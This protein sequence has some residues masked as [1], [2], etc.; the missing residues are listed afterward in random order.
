MEETFQEVSTQE[1]YALWARVY[2]EEKNALIAVEEPYVERL[3]SL[4]VFENALDVGTG[5]GRLALKLAHHGGRV[6]ALDQSPEMLSV[7]R[8]SAAREGLEID[9]RL[10]SLENGVFTEQQFDLLTSGLMLCHVP[11]LMHAAQQ[12][13]GALQTGGSALITDFHPAAIGYGW[14]TSFVRDGERYVLPNMPHTREGYIEALRVNGFKIVEAIDI[15]VG[16]VPDGYL[17]EGFA[18]RH[19]E[20]LFGLIILAQKV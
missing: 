12:F 9:F 20:K 13:A 15:R 19:R 11:D 2:D 7:A 4:L 3:L 8:Q 17:P 18:Q 16:E 10:G 1:G 6:T 5:T 14:R